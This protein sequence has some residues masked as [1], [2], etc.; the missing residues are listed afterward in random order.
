MQKAKKRISK[1]TKQIDELR[2]SYH[3]DNDPQVSD[4]VYDSL[5][6][7]LVEL[8]KK[9]P[10]LKRPDSPL[11]RIGG[12]PLDKFEKV[13]HQVQQWSFNDAFSQT[14]LTDWI[15][16]IEKI[17]IKQTGKQ[18]KLE[19]VCELKI[20]GLHI[21][22]TYEQ[23]SLKLAATR[24]DGKVGEN[25]TQNVRTIKSVPL[26]LTRSVDV[27][28]EGEVWMSAKQLEKINKQRRQAGQPEYA[29]P[30]NVA[31]G[32]IRQLDPKIVAQ[33]KLDCFIYDWSGGKDAAPGKHSQKLKDLKKLGFKVNDHYK[34][35]TNMDQI[36]SYWQNWEKKRQTQDYWI[37]GVVVKVN[38]QEYRDIL[39]Y[40]G[41]APRWAIAFK[42]AAEEVTTIV[43]DI[44]VQIGR[45]GTLTPVA[46]LKPVKLAGTTVKR[47]TLHN[48]D[49][50][51]R[52][53]VK[54]GDTVVI[55]KAG[56]IIP[57]VV[58]VLVKMR[59]GKER[60]FKMPAKCPDCGQAVKTKDITDKKAGASVALFCTNPQC[61]SQMQR[62]IQHFVSKKAFDIEGFGGK[63][64]E[65]LMSEDLLENA[66][67]IFK[68]GKEDLTPLERFADKAAENLIEA[69]N[70][71]KDVSLSRF[72]YALGIPHVGEETAIAL[73]DNFGNLEKIEV[74]SEDQLVNI[75]DIGPVVATSINEWF[76]HVHNSRLV[77]ALIRN[78]VEVKTQKVVKKSGPLLGKKIVVTGTLE[79]LGREE[80]K[81]KI[82]TAGGDWVSSVSKNTDYVVVGENPGSKYN[83][84]QGL[85]IKILS[86]KEFLSLVK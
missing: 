4:E 20:D 37:D 19:Y 10:G 3:V 57:E 8:E 85:G 79:S 48:E 9:F 66:A 58:S 65:Q 47:A 15:E 25:V 50:I 13:T 36:V 81:Q 80:V 35:C 82:R 55:R 46:H 61:F 72:V 68:L 32:T 84:A 31:A 16:R 11:S 64:V 38:Q 74:A 76:S 45:L 24:G 28:V 41:K 56:E 44:R 1:L 63:I 39:G 51:K 70:Q 52:L 30:R 7:E 5:Q 21:V 12:K 17:I 53:G 34:I 71:A 73:A 75:S 78:G 42:F 54:I 23:G 40:V 49:Q 27:I 59:T 83:K 77:K 67:D 6:K 43:E 2:Y 62:K 29:N 69:I 18:P 22:F 33:R 60:S 26:K 14:D 86:E